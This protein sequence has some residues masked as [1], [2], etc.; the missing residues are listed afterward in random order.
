MA[1]RKT[2]KRLYD[3]E[4]NREEKKNKFRFKDF[5]KAI[6]SWLLL[7][8]VAIIT[9]YAMATFFV[10]SVTVIGPSMEKTLSDGEVCLINKFEYRVHGIKRYDVVAYKLVDSDGYYDIKRVYGLPGET[11]C[12]KDGKI[13]I[14]D[15]E[16]VDR[17]INDVILTS[18]IANEKIVLGKDEYFILGDNINNSEDSRFS[19]VGNVSSTEIKGK[20][21]YVISPEGKRRKVK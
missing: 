7:V 6:R 2:S 18:G 9:G 10:Q 21:T 14:N 16:L 11:V 19:N 15:E 3:E 17:P 8:F 5:F 4:D 12:I 13:Y 1:K 20:V